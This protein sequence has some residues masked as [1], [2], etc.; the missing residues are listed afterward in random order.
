[1]NRKILAITKP[2]A[3]GYQFYSYPLAIILNHEES[4]PWFYSNF[5]QLAFDKNIFA[6]VPLCFYMYDYACNPWLNVHRLQRE[7]FSMLDKEI[8]DFVV[9]SIDRGYYVYLNVDEYFIPDRGDYQ[10]KHFSHDTLVYG[11]DLGL[12]TLK[13]LGFNKVGAYESSEVS[14][15][16]FSQSYHYL[17]KIENNCNQIYLYQYNQAGK[18]DFNAKLVKETLEDYLYSRNTSERFSMIA[19]PWDR[20]YG[21]E[22]YE[23]LQKYFQNLLANKV[24][25]DIRLLHILWEHKSCMKLRTEYMYENGFIENP[26]DVETAKL[27]EHKAFMVKKLFLKYFLTEKKEII[28]TVSQ[29]TDEIKELEAVFIEDLISGLIVK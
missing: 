12:R 27:I 25:T 1:M 11:Y 5:I 15:N 23:Y 28:E 6:P 22:S 9:D 19:E 8:V 18:Y 13:I 16:E 14:F 4:Y 3:N 2:P 10:K 7:T 29:L 21:M 20:A 26:N 17:D 24:H